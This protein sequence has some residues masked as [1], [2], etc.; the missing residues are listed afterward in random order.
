MGLIREPLEVDFTTDPRILT[1][2]E[3]IAISEY[4]RAYKEKQAKS[5][6]VKTAAKS[7]LVKH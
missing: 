5:G 2:E 1:Q 3:K 6:L 7:K 4:I